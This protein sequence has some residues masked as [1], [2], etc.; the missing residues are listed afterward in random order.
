MANYALSVL[1]QRQLGNEFTAAWTPALIARGVITVIIFPFPAGPDCCCPED[2]A[3]LH[4]SADKQYY[5]AS[6]GVQK[7]A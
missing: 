7:K 5:V 3:C 4:P 1:E 6:K 2:V